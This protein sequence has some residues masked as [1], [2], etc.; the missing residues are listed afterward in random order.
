MEVDGASMLQHEQEQ[1]EQEQQQQPLPFGP[2][3]PFA[4]LSMEIERGVRVCA[5]ARPAAAAAR[6]APRRPPVNTAEETFEWCDMTELE[7][8]ELSQHAPGT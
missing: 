1:H 4:P 3:L 2:L 8:N 6:A 7:D 5:A